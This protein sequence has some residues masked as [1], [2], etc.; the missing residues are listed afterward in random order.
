MAY[1]CFN[2]FIQK[3]FL[4]VYIHGKTDNRFQV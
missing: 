4:E 1:K 3:S 2:L